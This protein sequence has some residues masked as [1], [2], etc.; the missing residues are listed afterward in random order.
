M[1]HSLMPIST[2]SF[3]HYAIERYKWVLMSP[4]ISPVN[5][6]QRSALTRC[7]HHNHDTIVAIITITIIAI[8]L[9]NIHMC[10]NMC[11]HNDHHHHHYHHHNHHHHHHH[12]HHLDVEQFTL[13]PKNH[14]LYIYHHTIEHYAWVL[15]SPLASSSCV[16]VCV[17]VRVC[18]YVCVW[19][20]GYV[21]ACIGCVY[22]CLR[23]CVRVDKTSC[24]LHGGHG[25]EV[26]TP[27]IYHHHHHH[28]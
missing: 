4:F 26:S 9:L 6:I 1:C 12:H 17:C 25:K 11:V 13:Q 3:Y 14:Y 24:F 10:L 2:P 5:A 21:C 23:V 15:M 28:G 16:S 27:N 7:S 19:L 20:C 18:A 22:V 8:R